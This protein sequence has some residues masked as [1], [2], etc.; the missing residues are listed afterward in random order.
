MSFARKTIKSR[1][2]YTLKTIY[3]NY[4]KILIIEYPLI[5]KKISLEQLSYI[6]LI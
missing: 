6:T 5:F 3:L 1:R 2:E 4:I